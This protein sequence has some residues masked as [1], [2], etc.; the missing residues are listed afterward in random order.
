MQETIEKNS[1]L[2]SS[3]QR[4]CDQIIPLIQNMRNHTVGSAE[5]YN[6]Y[7]Q[8]VKNQDTKILAILKQELE[9]KT[10]T[11]VIEIFQAFASYC[12]EISYT[13]RIFQESL[14]VLNTE[15][16]IIKILAILFGAEKKTNRKRTKRSP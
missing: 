2:S 3:L 7:E 11:E 6:E 4:E 16:S 10:E 8:Q 1:P 9:D 14:D 15:K 5:K 13:P 12:K